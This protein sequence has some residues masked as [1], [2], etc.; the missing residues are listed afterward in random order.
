[1]V[2]LDQDRYAGRTLVEA[3]TATDARRE[4]GQAGCRELFFQSQPDFLRAANST[5][6]ARIVG[7]PEIGADKQIMLA[8]WHGSLLA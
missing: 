2:G 8:L 7:G 6:T 3:T 5:R 1:V 4:F